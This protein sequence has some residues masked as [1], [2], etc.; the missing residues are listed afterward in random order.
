MIHHPPHSVSSHCHAY[1]FTVVAELSGAKPTELR[2]PSGSAKP[3]ELQS[4]SGDA[5]ITE[6]KSPSGGAKT[7]ELKSPSGGAKHNE[8]NSPVITE[9][10]IKPSARPRKQSVSGE[11]L[12]LVVLTDCLLC[13][14][15]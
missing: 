3:T 8:Q 14:W 7:T 2:G 9:S 4:L 15:S 1:H 11:Y 5:K 13:S 10:P 12:L 6:L